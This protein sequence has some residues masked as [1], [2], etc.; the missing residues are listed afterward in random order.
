MAS[1]EH[2]I[3]EQSRA[4]IKAGNPRSKQ[5]VHK[6]CYL[7]EG[8]YLKYQVISVMSWPWGYRNGTGAILKFLQGMPH[9]VHIAGNFKKFIISLFLWS[10]DQYTNIASQAGNRTSGTPCINSVCQHHMIFQLNYHSPV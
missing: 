2:E 10:S 9:P 7:F 6:S 4:H 5:V 3:E 1:R 8:L